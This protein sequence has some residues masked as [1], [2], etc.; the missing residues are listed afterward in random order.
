[1]HQYRRKSITH[2]DFTISLSSFFEIDMNRN[3]VWYG[4]EWASNQYASDAVATVALL[5]KISAS[6]YKRTSLE[7][8]IVKVCAI[9][10]IAMLYHPKLISF[11]NAQPAAYNWTLFQAGSQKINAPGVYTGQNQVPGARQGHVAV[12]DDINYR[13]WMFGGWGYGSSGGE[14]KYILSLISV[15]LKF[16]LNLCYSRPLERFVVP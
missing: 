4:T 9:Q 6:L 1:M 15:G 5:F 12:F 14:G 3:R 13:M 10:I 8:K 7:M 11:I 16:G 2:I